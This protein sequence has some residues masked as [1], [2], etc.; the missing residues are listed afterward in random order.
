MVERKNFEHKVADLSDSGVVTIY[1]NSFDRED[2]DGDISV[3]GSFAKTIKENSQRIKHFLNHDSRLL[4][5]VPLE[6]KED[7]FGLLIRSQL[8]LK[9]ELGRDVYEDYK[10]YAEHG[11]TLEHSIG[12]NVV[13]RDSS[14]KAMITEYKLWEYS[15]LTNWGA[16]EWTPLVDLKSINV[17]PEEL[18]EKIQILT[19]MYNRKYS[20][21]RL[22]SI[23]IVLKDLTDSPDDVAPS[24][25]DTQ[26]I[27]PD[28]KALEIIKNFRK[29]LV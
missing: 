3:K 29:G 22:K 10:L 27:A 24:V 13:R 14:N 18:E 25:Q 16:N 15:T 17:T 11:K 28:K 8:N 21:T 12:F 7:D 4:V 5:G 9:K 2:S 20:D 23:E 1:G 6:M 19:E 26:V